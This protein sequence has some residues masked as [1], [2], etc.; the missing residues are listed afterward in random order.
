MA[1]VSAALL[2][3]TL[4]ARSNVQWSEQQL[5]YLQKKGTIRMCVAPDWMPIEGIDRQGRH[6]GMAAG[7]IQLMARRGG[8]NI[9]LV[10]ARTWEE[11]F[12]LGQRRECDIF[13]LLMDSP[14]RRS[15]LDFTSPYLEIPGVIATSVNVP[16][17]AGLE[18][19]MG[20]RLG[21]MRG[22]AGIELLRL[23]HPGIQLIE[24]N[25]YEE[26]LSK[27]QNGELFGF[28]GNMMSIGHALQENK[29]YDVKIAGRIE[30]DNLM[31][32]ATRNDEPML[33]EIFQTLVDSIEPRERQ[34]IMNRWM[35]VRFEQ[36][37]D[38]RLFWRALA[39]I[40]LVGAV[41]VFWATKLRRLNNE[42]R[43]V[44]KRLAEIS[45]HDALTGLHNRLHFD[46][47]VEST[48]HLCARNG[49]TMT[50]A[51]I[52]LD[53]F[54]EINDTFGHPFGDAC[55]RHV[56]STLAKSFRRDTDTTIRYGGE[57]LIVISVGGTAAEMVERLEAF[58]LDIERSLVALESRQTKLTVSIGVWSGVP[59]I[60]HDAVRI[61]KDADAALYR[62]KR[63]GRNQLIAADDQTADR[64][65]EQQG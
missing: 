49:L 64:P 36:G 20:E 40:L 35:A 47:V 44:N 45:R 21:H 13:S 59:R 37:F 39:V 57:E 2:C 46:E 16:F 41:T 29:I 19:V 51:V 33:L 62:A 11:S 48:L 63:A 4:P 7:F 18:Q 26:G 60:G 34:E 31:S 25:S 8:L 43:T 38:Y 22:F 65:V 56:A 27:V 50:L 1:T 10:P 6:V 30:H 15:F 5:A 9:Q 24:V 14:S 61:L 42:L 55:L 52:D 32:I 28:I 3:G 23:R 12:A 54:K 58:R 53:R 17:V